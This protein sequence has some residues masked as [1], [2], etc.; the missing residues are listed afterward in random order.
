MRNR[1]AK[2]ITTTALSLALAATPF[3]ASAQETTTVADNSATVAA[4]PQRADVLQQVSQARDV[5]HQMQ[6]DADLAGL[7]KKAKGIFVVPDFGRAAAVVGVRGGTGMLITNDNGTWSGPA[8]YNM[9]GISVGAQIGASGGS[10]AFLL[11]DQNAVN[12]FMDKNSFSLNADAG[13]SI[14]NYSA[15]TQASWGKGDII[16]WSDTEGAFAGA[17]ISATDIM[18]DGQANRAYYGK[19]LAPSDVLMNANA[20]TNVNSLDKAFA[21]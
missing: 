11:M 3:A 16:M 19:Q 9:G 15:N 5:I 7:M 10:I 4:S 8:F 2:L 6:Q 14:I 20:D 1:S 17:E 21:S 12:Q 18:W 13:L